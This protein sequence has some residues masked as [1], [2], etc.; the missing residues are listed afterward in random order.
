MPIYTAYIKVDL[1]LKPS[2]LG[3]MLQFW[4]TQQRTHIVCSRQ[5]DV[6]LPENRVY[7][8][9]KSIFCEAP[10]SEETFISVCDVPCHDAPPQLLYVQSKK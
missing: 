6:E 7:G 5:Y 10:H 9:K 1:I 2:P 4:P 8:S 3:T